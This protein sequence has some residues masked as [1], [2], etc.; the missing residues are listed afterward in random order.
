MGWKWDATVTA[1]VSA[2][3]WKTQLRAKAERLR[4]TLEEWRR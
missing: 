2:P 3:G 4:R 1:A